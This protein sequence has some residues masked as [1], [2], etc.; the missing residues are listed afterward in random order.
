MVFCGTAN[1][2]V[3][4][5]V[6]GR[7]R[8]AN[9]E[10][11]SDMV[12]ALGDRWDLDRSDVELLCECG[13]LGC[14]SSIIVPLVEYLDARSNGRDVVADCHEGP[15]DLVLSR[16][17]GY[18][19]VAPAGKPNG[20]AAI[21]DLSCPCGQPYRVAARGTHLILW[22]RNSATGFRREPIGDR[23]VNGCAIDRFGV[24]YEVMA[25]PRDNPYG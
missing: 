12:A 1:R 14:G 20:K 3:A 11:A 23:C 25:A 16:S 18:R 19:V 5:D 10:L 8:T 7:V 15:L 9:W 6:T 24:L 13:R 21:G 22:P 17:D 4:D 2:S